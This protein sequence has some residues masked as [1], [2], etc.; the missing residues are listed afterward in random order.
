MFKVLI[1]YGLLHTINGASLVEHAGEIIDNYDVLILQPPMNVVKSTN[2]PYIYTT[3]SDTDLFF[4]ILRGLKSKKIYPYVPL[5]GLDDATW[6]RFGAWSNL[7]N[8]I[9]Y[10]ISPLINFYQT[11]FSSAG[12]DYDGYFFDEFGYDYFQNYHPRSNWENY[13]SSAV[14]LARPKSLIFN[15]WFFGRDVCPYGFFDGTKD[16]ILSESIF[17]RSNMMYY[18]LFYT[19]TWLKKGFPIIG[20][21]SMDF[22][23]FQI[24]EGFVDL[25]KS[26]KK[27]INDYY[28]IVNFIGLSGFGIVQID[29]GASQPLVITPPLDNFDSYLPDC[30]IVYEDNSLI[31]INGINK[32]YAD[33][34][35]RIIKRG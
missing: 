28:Q 32:I 8:A 19:N 30:E 5:F 22:S 15:A 13:V 23:S 18:R 20:V 9:N 3:T 29:Y 17:A 7:N 35:L 6:G 34:N 31:F 26:T 21:H 10:V 33:V 25:N 11:I 24:R 16:Y 14:N 2:S 1:H 12:V 27:L 4:E